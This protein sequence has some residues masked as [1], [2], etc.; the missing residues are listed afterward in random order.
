[1]NNISWIV[2]FDIYVLCH[3]KKL[4]KV[5]ITRNKEYLV[6]INIINDNKKSIIVS[7]IAK[8]KDWEKMYFMFDD[9]LT[10]NRYFSK[11]LLN[12]FISITKNSR[13]M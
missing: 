9:L 11:H 13:S 6:D 1:M 3:F 12:V 8:Q 4:K 5:F 10:N 2:E 7:F